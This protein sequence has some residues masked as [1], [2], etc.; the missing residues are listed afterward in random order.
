MSSPLPFSSRWWLLV[1]LCAVLIIIG[2][3]YGRVRDVLRVSAIG[4]ESAHS[5]ARHSRGHWLVVP[6]HI[7]RSYQW[8]AETEQ[9]VTQGEPRVRFVRYE[10]A[11]VGREVNTP[12]PYRWWLGFVRWIALHW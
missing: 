8:L 4:R 2:I 3:D 1:P 7:S 10:N 12:S 5:E 6:E 11:P 9:M